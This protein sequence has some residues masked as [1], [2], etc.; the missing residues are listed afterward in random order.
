MKDTIT[1]IGLDVHKDS[2]CIALCNDDAVERCFGLM[3][4][5]ISSAMPSRVT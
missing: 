4:S 1:Y 3:P 5:H 2:I